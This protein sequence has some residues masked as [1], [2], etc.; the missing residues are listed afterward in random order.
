V[1]T[2]IT[3]KQLILT[4]AAKEAGSERSAVWERVQREL[5]K[6]TSNSSSTKQGSAGR[7]HEGKERDVK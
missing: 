5:A 2:Y 7:P 3:N 6:G 4:A 1:Y